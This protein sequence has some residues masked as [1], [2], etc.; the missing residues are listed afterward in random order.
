MNKNR[1]KKTNLLIKGESMW[2][3]DSTIQFQ[4]FKKDVKEKMKVKK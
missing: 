3:N 1:I 2:Q 4:C